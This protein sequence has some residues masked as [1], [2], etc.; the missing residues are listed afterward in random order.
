MDIQTKIK[1]NQ[2]KPR[3]YQI[4]IIN[5]LEEKGFKRI[6]LCWA[7]RSGKDHIAFYLAIRQ[8]LKK[9][10]TIFYM[11]PT[12]RQARMCL[13]DGINIEGRRI[14]DYIPRELIAR[15]NESEMKIEL[16]NGSILQLAG[17]DNFDSL[18]GSN[19]YGCIFSE[20][21]LQDPQGWSFLRPV[22]AANDG[23]A[24]FISTPRGRNHFWEL[25]QLAQASDKWFYS[26]LTVDDTKHISAEALFE[27][28]KEMSEDLFEQEYKCSFDAGVEGAYYTKYLDKMKLNN[29]IT[30]VPYEVGFPVHTAWDL[31]MSDSTVIIFFQTIG[32]SIR[33]IDYYE[34]ADRGLEHYISLVKN[35]EYIYGKHIAP[36]D[37]AVRELGTGMSRLEKSRSLGVSFVTAPN[38]PIIDGIEA[39]RSSLSKI[40]IDEKKCKKLIDAIDNYRK[41]WDSKKKVYRDHPRHDQYS[42]AC[43]SGNMNILTP[44][45]SVE[46]KD[47]NVGDFVVTPLG[48]R[49]VLNIHKRTSSNLCTIDTYNNTRIVCT[50]EHQIFTNSGLSRADALRYGVLLEPYAKLRCFLWKKI[51]GLCTEGHGIK[52]FKK[53]IL[54]LKMKKPLCFTDSFIDGMVQNT[55]W[56]PVMRVMEYIQQFKDI[57]GKRISVKF[58]LALLY[59]IK[60]AIQGIMTL[61]IL[62]FLRQKNMDTGMR[63][64]KVRGLNPMPVKR[65]LFHRVKKQRNGIGALKEERGIE[66]MPSHC[67]EC[68]ELNTQSNVCFVKKN[69]KPVVCGESIVVM[70]AKREKEYLIELIL[71]SVH[72][73]F[74]KQCFHVIN[75]CLKKHAVKNVQISRYVIPKEVYDLTV[76]TDNCYYVNGYLVSNCD[77]LRYLCLSLP[78]TRTDTSPEELEKRYQEVLYGD[79][80]WNLPP[81][82]R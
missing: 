37:I 77:A 39:V 72:A 4:P 15:K 18:V 66:S 36:H 71:K 51:F 20:F 60:M 55:I 6:L 40:W 11:F 67:L 22:L 17:S 3:D 43:F 82:F 24:L 63:R 9:V 23:W 14:I 44:N 69:I 45:G 32:Q 7:R 12:Y 1:L 42:H 73:L 64:E 75:M 76:E 34:N 54:S 13:W 79:S 53:T 57:F 61:P 47:I 26:R 31:G 48:N 65:C 58:P 33:I 29:Q 46:I 74:V 16:V 25:A 35:K 80:R 78:K 52:G 70:P 19:P 49:R 81:M 10:C 2:F 41:E 8:M 21:S 28:R 62:N 56:E 59:I 50:P 38:L 30:D 68:K 5:A 27:E